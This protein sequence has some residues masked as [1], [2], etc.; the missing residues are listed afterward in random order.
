MASAGSIRFRHE[1]GSHVSL[2]G[3]ESD[4]EWDIGH[5]AL[6]RTGQRQIVR[7]LRPGGFLLPIKSKY[8][9]F[10]HMFGAFPFSIAIILTLKL[11]SSILL[12]HLNK[13]Q[14]KE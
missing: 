13:A 1:R 8:F 2:Y 4:G 10:D 12:W 7:V 6:Q 9:S 5:R 14:A 3:K 11:L